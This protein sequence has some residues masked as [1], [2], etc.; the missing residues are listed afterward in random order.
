MDSGI[1][2]YMYFMIVFHY[3]LEPRAECEVLGLTLTMTPVYY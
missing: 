2:K 3:T 1:Q